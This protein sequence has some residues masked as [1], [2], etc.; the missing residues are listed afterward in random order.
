MQQ[1]QNIC[2][3]IRILFFFICAIIFISNYSFDQNIDSDVF[4][5]RIMQNA[6]SNQN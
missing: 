5:S 2:N 4:W 6:V 3:A 1:M